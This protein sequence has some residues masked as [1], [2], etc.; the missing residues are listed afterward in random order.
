[1][2]DDGDGFVDLLDVLGCTGPEDDDETDPPL[3]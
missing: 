3:P 2:D 1:V